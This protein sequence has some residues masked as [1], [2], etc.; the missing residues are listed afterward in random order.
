MGKSNC[1]HREFLI[2]AE[3]GF[4]RAVVKLSGLLKAEVTSDE[5]DAVRAALRVLDVDWD[6]TTA[7]ERRELITRSTVAARAKT[8]PI[9]RKTEAVFGKEGEEV[10]RSTR[11]S[12]RR[13][14]KLSIGVD[15]NAMDKRIVKYLETSETS[16]VRDE[17]GRRN[18]AFSK[19][20][21]KV[22]ADGL[23]A[24]LG[25]DDIS[26][27]LAKAAQ[28]TIAGRGS[29]YWDVVAGSFISR[30]R[31]FA[32]LS[33]F[34]EARIERYRFEA[35]LDEVTTD[36][37]RFFHGKI[38][39][40][41]SGLQL[42]EQVEQKPENLKELNP[43]IRTVKNK[44]GKTE[45]YVTQGGERVALATVERSGVGT[46]DERGVFASGLKE[47]E[48]T[49]LGISFPP[50]HGLCRS[51]LLGIFT[52]RKDNQG[53][54]F[55]GHFF[56]VFRRASLFITWGTQLRLSR[57]IWPIGEDTFDN[58]FRAYRHYLMESR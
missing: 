23:E 2:V 12:T 6:N 55:G 19:Q 51:S 26:R 8:T 46:R 42:F 34:S 39:S 16:F 50:L 24:G 28:N 58:H 31:S 38:F 47:K 48:L 45:L 5:Q 49:D 33:S 41:D 1:R 7:A 53:L 40:V 14:Q 18:S 21:S 25:R 37:C 57:T 44:D 4:D 17:Y 27:D 15:F 13:D 3:Q 35:V 20:A 30:G 56:R 54:F 36:T 32:Q 22:V 43:W 10:V 9:P 11:L 29:P 52:Y